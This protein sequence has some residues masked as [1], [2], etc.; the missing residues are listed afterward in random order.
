MDT[1]KV[2]AAIAIPVGVKEVD[3]DTDM[4]ASGLRL[5]NLKA[6]RNLEDIPLDDEYWDASRAHQKAYSRNK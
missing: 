1:T 5:A 3:L 6:G 2:P 4:D